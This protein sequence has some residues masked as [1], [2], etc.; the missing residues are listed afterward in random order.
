MPES[1][2]YQRHRTAQTG[3]AGTP[4]APPRATT[5]KSRCRRTSARSRLLAPGACLTPRSTGPACQPLGC[6]GTR[7]QSHACHALCK[8]TAAGSEG[9]RRWGRSRSSG[10]SPAP[11][12]AGVCGKARVW[13]AYR[14]RT[15]VAAYFQDHV[16]VID[17]ARN[18]IPARLRAQAISGSLGTQHSFPPRGS[19]VVVAV[20]A[21]DDGRL[22][23]GVSIPLCGRARAC[24]RQH[25]RVPA[26]E[27][28]ALHCRYSQH[29]SS[30]FRLRL[31]PEFAT[32]ALVQTGTAD[33]VLH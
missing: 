17:A 14:S 32:L 4:D 2:L 30:C 8:R 15:N 22:E 7:G 25:G 31:A 12:V 9:Q 5:S 18:Q 23:L 10:R 29:T 33:L 20:F 28:A 26:Q 21:G 13:R 19:P 3:C 16:V 27:L 11:R 1:G 6:C 24:Q